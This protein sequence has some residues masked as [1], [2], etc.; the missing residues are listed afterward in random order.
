MSS[1]LRFNVRSLP[2]LA[3]AV[4]TLRLERGLTQQQLADS[5]DVSRK[6]VS[7]LEK[8]KVEGLEVVRLLRVLDAL[9]AILTIEAEP[10]PEPERFPEPSPKLEPTQD[11]ASVFEEVQE[12]IGLEREFEILARRV[13][14]ALGH[15]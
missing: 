4:K 1:Q 7:T 15:L 14:E 6:W 13:D 8:G 12:Q 10:T 2:R 9:D 3:R 5:A 11:P